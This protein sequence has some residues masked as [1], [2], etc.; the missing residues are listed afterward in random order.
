VVNAAIKYYAG[1]LTGRVRFGIRIKI[2][3]HSVS[4][5]SLIMRFLPVCPSISLSVFH[6][7]AG[8]DK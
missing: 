1:V 2:H 8:L 5:T 3:L 4:A 7:P 6:L